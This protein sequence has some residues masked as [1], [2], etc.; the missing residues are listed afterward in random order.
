MRHVVNLFQLHVLLLLQLTTAG[1]RSAVS[2]CD[3][4]RSSRDRS[5]RRESHNRDKDKNRASGRSD[6]RQE[7]PRENDNPR[8]RLRDEELAYDRR[9]DRNRNNER[10][11]ESR[12][13]HN[14]RDYYEPRDRYDGRDRRDDRDRHDDRYDDGDRKRS[15][16]YDSYRDES[17]PPRR[18][19]EHGRLTPRSHDDRSYRNSSPYDRSRPSSRAGQ[20]LDE[21]AKRAARLAKLQAMKNQIGDKTVKKLEGSPVVETKGSGPKFGTSYIRPSVGAYAGHE[22]PTKAYKPA[23][24]AKRAAERLA[25]DK[26]TGKPSAALRASMAELEAMSTRAPYDHDTNSRTFSNLS[27]VPT[28]SD[29]VDTYEDVDED[30]IVSDDESKAVARRTAEQRARE[31]QKSLPRPDTR[32]ETVP[33]GENVGEDVDPLDAFMSNLETPKEAKIDYLKDIRGGKN[34]AA[35]GFNSDDEEVNINAMDNSLDDGP[36]K[37]ARFWPVVDHAEMDYEPFRKDFYS[38]S[39]ELADITEEQLEVLRAE[40]ENITVTGDNVPKPIQTFPQGGFGSQI[41]DVIRSLEFQK[42]TAIQSQALSAIMSGRD[43]LAVAKT[44]SGKTMA[45]L[46]PMFRHV[47]DQR[48]LKNGEGP[49]ALIIVPTRE[50]AVQVHKECKPFLSTLGLRASCCYGGPPISEHIAELKRGAEIVVATPGRLID[51]IGSNQ[52]RVTNMARV[53]YL[54]LDEADR[55]FD[56]GFGKQIQQVVQLIRPTKQAVLF[57]ATLPQSMEHFALRALKNPVQIT[58]GGRSVV[59]DEIEQIIEVISVPEKFKRLLHYL[60]NNHVSDNGNRSLIFVERQEG[61]DQLHG[62]LLGM[63]YPV[64]SIHGGRDQADRDQF[65]SDFKR[66]VVDVLVATSVAARGL[67]VKQLSLVVNY[68]CPNHHEDYVHRCGRTGRAGNKGLAVTFITNDETRYAPFLVKALTDSNT[69][70]PP[71]LQA[72]ADEFQNKVK[73]GELKEHTSGFGGHGIARLQAG[74]DMERALV[75]K[76]YGI[77]GVELNPEDM[78][79]DE[80]KP[81][82]SKEVQDTGRS[83]FERMLKEAMVVTKTEAPLPVSKQRAGPANTGS[84]GGST[85][86]MTAL[87]RAAAAAASVNKDRAGGATRDTGRPIDNHGPDAGA[88][89]AVLQVNDLPQSARWYVTQRQNVAKVL[90]A[91]HVSITTKGIF[92]EA[93]KE[94]KAGEQP[95]LYSLVEGDTAVAVETA[96]HQL[97]ELA[98]EGLRKHETEAAAKPT[99]GRYSV[100]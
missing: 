25:R 6:R 41:L 93:G 95:K 10:H 68:D 76:K 19:Q 8:K 85:A 24:I 60:G 84:R 62:L 97:C 74:R 26:A 51:L 63:G 69:A 28:S 71:A 15:R 87:Q 38:E 29:P 73:T 94:P 100:V 39:T 43:T 9:D 88:Y 22:E 86:G 14:G 89:H 66:G 13:R 67:D 56:M 90:E 50:L 79:K 82:A 64:H 59:A 46:L 52:G 21:G 72:L 7:R 65:I 31:A 2:L 99:T 92:Y 27:S 91:T 18:G 75:A 42:P 58:V 33:A 23:E 37:K 53:T 54:V 47:K 78:I 77:D 40:L 96:M 16:R 3:E 61:A 36:K 48:P 55:M 5:R 44:G 1:D 98:R 45:Y 34:R 30:L 35:R 57:S 81:E 32:P 11:Y 4:P 49:I 17:P 12:D 70:V 83:E 20:E 80:K